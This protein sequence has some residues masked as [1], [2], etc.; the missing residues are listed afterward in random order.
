MSES[1]WK[2][3]MVSFRFVRL[4]REQAEKFASLHPDARINAK[5]KHEGEYVGWVDLE[6]GGGR[7]DWVESFAKELHPAADDYGLFVSLTTEID[8]DIIRVPDFALDLSR[9]AGGVIDFSYTYVGPDEE[10]PPEE[11]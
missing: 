6:A 1:A 10:D 7:Y 11:S 4:N 8:T 3:V 2:S 9:R 5:R